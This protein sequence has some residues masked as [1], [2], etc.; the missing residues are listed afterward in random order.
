MKELLERILN[1][2]VLDEGQCEV[3]I[4]AIE[5][6]K[7]NTCQLTAILIGI[8]LRGEQLTELN[9]FRKAL[10]K[11]TVTTDL[12]GEKAIDL[13]GTGGDGKNTFNIS[14]ASSFIL[15]ALGYRVIKH[16]NYGVSSNCG[17]STV[18][19]A[20]GIDLTA[21]PRKLERSFN[22]NNCCFLHAPLFHPT[23]KKVG[24]L[25]KEL[26]IRTIFNALGPLVNPVQPKYQLTGTFSLEL[27]RSYAHILR[28]ERL[29][30]K[31]VHGMNGYDE[32][33]LCDE[34]RLFGS[35]EDKV[36]QAGDYG[37]K[38]LDPNTLFAA[39]SPTANA[40][41]IR[42]LLNG[43]GSEE[44]MDVVA[45]NVT[46]ARLL[47]H[48]GDDRKSLFEDTRKFIQSGKTAQHFKLN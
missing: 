47:F 24:T 17:S 16:G 21:D 22:Q 48:P 35:H 20:L 38:K 25:R 31:V 23:L 9:G 34:T 32:L 36:L 18:L 45:A 30:F 19:E 6:E 13:C 40:R 43:K 2:E 33:T 39:Q 28:N 42:E 8:H 44:Q 14:T 12:D 3:L 15:A 1:K 4:D 27:A 11:R 10:L 7:V 46:E 41:L 29:A 5:H 26:G 37:R